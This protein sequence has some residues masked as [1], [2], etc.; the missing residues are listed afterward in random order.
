MN[1]IIVVYISFMYF[2]PPAWR[3][4]FEVETCCHIKAVTYTSCVDGILFL[5]LY[6][7]HSKSIASIFVFLHPYMVLNWNEV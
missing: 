3:W 1:I 2:T 5:L 4:P 6:K 7:G